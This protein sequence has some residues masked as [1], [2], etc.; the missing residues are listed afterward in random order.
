MMSFVWANEYFIWA[1]Q[2][3]IYIPFS[4]IQASERH[5]QRH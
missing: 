5:G 1:N 3:K 2:F 4:F